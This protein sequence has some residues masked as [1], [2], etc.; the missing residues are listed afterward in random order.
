MNITYDKQADALY[1]Y[2]QKGVFVANKEIEEGVILDIGKNNTLLGVEILNA[3]A[4]VPIENLVS[5]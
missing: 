5:A 2:L 3:S 4:R 1:I